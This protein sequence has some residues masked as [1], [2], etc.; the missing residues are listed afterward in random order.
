MSLR[1]QVL[2]RLRVRPRCNTENNIV[3]NKFQKNIRKELQKK[4]D[5]SFDFTENIPF[6]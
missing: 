1:F 5:A 2:R 3:F 6:Y 4:I